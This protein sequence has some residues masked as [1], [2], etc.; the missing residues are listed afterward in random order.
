MFPKPFD[1]NILLPFPSSVVGNRLPKR[2]ILC[3][4]A[5][6]GYNCR[7]LCSSQVSR[8]HRDI[9]AAK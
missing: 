8:I 1:G 9:E 7:G 6:C 5:R 2:P 3:M 4:I